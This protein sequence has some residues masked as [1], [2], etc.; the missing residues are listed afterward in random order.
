MERIR[1]QQEVDRLYQT[2]VTQPQEERKMNNSSSI[3]NVVANTVDMMIK[4]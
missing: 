1:H 4:P 2:P 3:K